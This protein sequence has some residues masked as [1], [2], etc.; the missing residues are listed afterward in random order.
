MPTHHKDRIVKSEADLVLTIRL[1][2]SHVETSRNLMIGP[3]ASL[4]TLYTEMIVE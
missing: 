4:A 3:Y 1:V 2:Y